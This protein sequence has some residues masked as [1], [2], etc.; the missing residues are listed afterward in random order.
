MFQS[1]ALEK[2]IND[3]AASLR[4]DCTIINCHTNE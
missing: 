1:K 4:I 2:H 3:C